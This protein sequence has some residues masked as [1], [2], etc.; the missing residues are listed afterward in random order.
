MRKQNRRVCCDCRSVLFR[1][2]F[3]KGQ[4]IGG[5][6]HT[7]ALPLYVNKFYLSY[8]IFFCL[9][10]P[11]QMSPGVYLCWQEFL[12]YLVTVVVFPA[13]SVWGMWAAPDTHQGHLSCCSQNFMLYFRREHGFHDDSS[14]ASC[15]SHD[16]PVP[17]LSISAIL[18]EVSLFRDSAFFFSMFFVQRAC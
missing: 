17:L 9:K 11:L 3:L 4:R 1:F 15:Y 2:S 10:A 5:Y 8:V 18:G 13:L 12:L 7:R 6:G 16:C 14:V